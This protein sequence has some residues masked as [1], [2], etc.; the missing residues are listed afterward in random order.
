MAGPLVVEVERL[1][2]LSDLHQPPRTGQPANVPWLQVGRGVQALPPERLRAALG[3]AVGGQQRVAAEAI[4]QIHQQQLLVL[5]LVLQAQL[6]QGEAGLAARRRLPLEQRRQLGQGPIHPLPPGQHLADARPAEQPPLGARMAG[7]HRLVVAVEQEAPALRRHR[8]VQRQPFLQQRPQQELL[9]EPG[10][11]A[12][13]PL[14]RAGVRHPLQAEVLGLQRGDQLHTPAA[15]RQQ[16][17]QQVGAHAAS[18][19]R[20]PAQP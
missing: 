2:R 16:P 1:A 7:T 9:E 19:L 6:Q 10:G 13:V 20:V 8:V 3:C 11:V 4:E 12:Q 5:L 18:L 17:L 14:G 15:H